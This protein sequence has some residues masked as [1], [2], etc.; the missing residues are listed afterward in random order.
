M[1]IVAVIFVLFHRNLPIIL[2]VGVVCSF[3]VSHVVRSYPG[4]VS[5]DHVFGHANCLSLR[6]E[7]ERT[8]NG[9]E[10]CTSF[11]TRSFVFVD[12]SSCTITRLII[13]I[14]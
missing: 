11:T 7:A 10:H 3:A 9:V 8:S 13:I 1:L 12:N 6:F 2:D 14:I 5:V 4:P